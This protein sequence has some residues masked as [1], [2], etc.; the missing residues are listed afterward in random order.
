ML[1]FYKLLSKREKW[2]KKANAKNL[3]LHKKEA[4][5]SKCAC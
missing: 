1:I 4:K 5:R 3:S 2:G